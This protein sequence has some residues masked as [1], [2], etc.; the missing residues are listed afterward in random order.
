MKNY[1]VT[2]NGTAY[3]VCVEEIVDGMSAAPVPQKSAP[4]PKA[5]TPAPSSPT[6]GTKIVA[7]MP[8]NIL[9]IKVAV[10]D[11]VKANQAVVILEAMKMENEIVSSVAGKVLAVNVSK[12][13]SVN[14][15][16]CL[17]V[18]G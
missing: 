9:D 4:A 14:T 7:P 17:V 6:A 16:D 5:A 12:G 11:T 18:V 10:G 15:D 3:D 2:V 1:R 8:G 13:A